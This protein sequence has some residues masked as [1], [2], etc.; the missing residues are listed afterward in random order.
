MAWII[1]GDLSLLL[2]RLRSIVSLPANGDLLR[3]D[4][5]E[6]KG[7]TMLISWN[8]GQEGRKIHVRW[9]RNTLKAQRDRQLEMG[10]NMLMQLKL[11][12]EAQVMGGCQVKEV[13]CF[14]A[15]GKGLEREWLLPGKKTV[16]VTLFWTDEKTREKHLAVSKVQ[17]WRIQNLSC[18][19]AEAT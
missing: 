8:K 2:A 6:S 4:L 12:Q 13:A 1:G 5:K 11:Q 7:F 18:G 10:S 16:F 3:K 9:L 14:H 17:V 19:S 15:T